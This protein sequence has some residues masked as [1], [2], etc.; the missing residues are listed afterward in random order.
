MWM[1]D[2][3][4]KTPDIVL[5]MDHLK[6]LLEGLREFIPEQNK[7]FVQQAISSL[8]EEVEFD[9]TAVNQMHLA[10][11]VFQDAV[12]AVLRKQNIMPHWVFALDNLVR[13][14]VQ[15]AISI[16]SPELGENLEGKN[17]EGDLDELGTVNSTKSVPT[18]Y[19]NSEVIHLHKKNDELMKENMRLMEEMI[20]I[21]QVYHELLKKNIEEKKTLTQM[22]KQGAFPFLQS[23]GVNEQNSSKLMSPSFKS[24]SFSVEES[25]L[26]LY[27]SSFDSSSS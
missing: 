18:L 16:L 8:K 12:K 26:L 4:Q 21:N 19:V 1:N 15:A 13:S 9:G 22:L 23:T 20:S 3:S 10:L 25:Y 2:L 14:A 11:Y 24:G 6:V 5:T 17:N 7:L 27:S